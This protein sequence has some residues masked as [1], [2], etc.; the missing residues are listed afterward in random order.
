MD[1]PF[2]AVDPV[3]RAQLQDEFLQLQREIGKTVIMVT[4]NIDE[5]LTLGDQVAV[6]RTGG[7]LAQIATPRDLLARPVDAFVAEFI[8]RDHGYRRPSFADDDASLPLCDE[9]RVL[10]GKTRHAA[11]ETALERWVLAADDAGQPIGWADVTFLDAPLRKE[12][13]N[14]N[15]T[16]APHRNSLR[17]V[18]DAALSSPSGC[19]VVLDPSA[20]LSGAVT[21]SNVLATIEGT[22]GI[23]PEP[24]P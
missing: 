12:D 19:G 5:A 21:L 24:R 1:E 3:V 9:P 20:G 13:L 8:G 22:R 2:S 23:Q 7:T 14:L 10:V 6:L 18:L 4:H 17:H 11:R 15:R 16:S